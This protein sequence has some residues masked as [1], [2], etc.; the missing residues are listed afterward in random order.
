MLEIKT[1]LNLFYNKFTT[2]I[3]LSKP[4]PSF[5]IRTG[6]PRKFVNN[7]FNHKPNISLDFFKYFSLN[8]QIDLDK[9]VWDHIKYS[10]RVYKFT[11]N[12]FEH[13]EYKDTKNNILYIGRYF[14]KDNN[15][16]MFKSDNT[17]YIS[18]R[19]FKLID[20]N[21]DILV[22]LDTNA[23]PLDKGVLEIE[24][25]NKVKSYKNILPVNGKSYKDTLPFYEDN[26]VNSILNLEEFKPKPK[27]I[28]KRFKLGDSWQN[29]SDHPWLFDASIPL[30]SS[31]N[32]NILA[33]PLTDIT[34]GG[35]DTEP[36][37]ELGRQLVPLPVGLY[38]LG[39]NIH[40]CQYDTYLL[41][42][43]KFLS[44][45][46]LPLTY[47]DVTTKFAPTIEFIQTLAFYLD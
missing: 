3:D 9:S 10:S 32:T 7:Y 15:L 43:D 21:K 40:S 34:V 22:K 24:Y 36:L 28:P 11:T 18:V 6:I 1:S 23:P 27:H 39:M 46:K 44:S 35:S 2:P 45:I 25:P 14:P 4:R 20:Y 19:S 41:V 5:I 42:W 47:T 16:I 13:I 31:F 12:A 8:H 17:G 37:P 38:P 26:K 29:T 30:P 33:F